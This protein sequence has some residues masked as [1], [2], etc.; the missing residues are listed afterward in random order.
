MASP[1]PNLAQNRIMTIAACVALLVLSILAVGFVIWGARRIFSKPGQQRALLD[2]EV[3][4][5]ATYAGTPHT[6]IS[7]PPMV[8]HYLNLLNDLLI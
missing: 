5:G 4:A 2:V 6:K 8:R 7:T 3:D 1:S